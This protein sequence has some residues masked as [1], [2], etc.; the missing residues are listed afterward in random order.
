MKKVHPWSSLHYNLT[1]VDCV[2][3]LYQEWIPKYLGKD[4]EVQILSPMVRGSLGT[5]N[6]N[7]VIQDAVNPSGKGKALLQV[8]ERI[9]REGD[10]VIHRR[11]NYD[12]GVFNGDIGRISS[13]DTEQLRCTVTFSPNSRQIE[14]Q[15]DDMME[16]DLAYAITI[17]KSQGSEFQAVILPVFTQHFTMLFRNLL[18][19]GLTRGRKLAVLVGSRKALA[20]AVGREDSRSRQTALTELIRGL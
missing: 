9:Y 12:L 1:G 16:L 7:K 4:C 20:M 19:T 14:Y 13:I 10:R 18:Y 2:R 15:R 11:N 6:L 3:R 5:A 17:H 8:G